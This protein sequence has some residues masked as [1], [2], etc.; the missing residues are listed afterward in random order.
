MT[1]LY[2]CRRDLRFY[3]HMPTDCVEQL[4]SVRLLSRLVL[5]YFPLSISSV[6]ITRQSVLTSRPIRPQG[7]TKPKGGKLGDLRHV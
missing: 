3:L 7:K 5:T 4:E 6:R 1:L 2:G